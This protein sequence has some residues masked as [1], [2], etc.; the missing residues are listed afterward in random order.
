[1]GRFSTRDCI[2]NFKIS[3]KTLTKYTKE[4]KIYKNKY[5]FSREP[6]IDSHN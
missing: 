1:L 3:H 4:Q 5:Y 6:Y 2:L